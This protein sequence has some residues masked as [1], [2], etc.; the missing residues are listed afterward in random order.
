MNCAG[1]RLQTATQTQTDTLIT[2]MLD[3]GEICTSNGI[4]KQT[5]GFQRSGHRTFAGIVT[6]ILTRGELDLRP[7]EKDTETYDG[8]V[9]VFAYISC[10]SS[11]RFTWWVE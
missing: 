5:H 9:N 7:E 2:G 6:V 11:R 1:W 8:R 10:A 3:G 4:R